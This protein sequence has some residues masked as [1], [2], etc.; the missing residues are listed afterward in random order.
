MGDDAQR[1]REVVERAEPDLLPYLTDHAVF[2]IVTRFINGGARAE[3][4][5]FLHEQWPTRRR[6]PNPRRKRHRPDTL[7][8]RCDACV[9]VL[10]RTGATAITAWPWT[11]AR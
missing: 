3:A 7:Y 2:R 8:F 4:E 1:R 10:D 11:Y 9:F 6:V 5:A